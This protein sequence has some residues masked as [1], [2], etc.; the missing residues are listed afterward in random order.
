MLDEIRALSEVLDVNDLDLIA[1]HLALDVELLL[2]V[3]RLDLRFLDAGVLLGWREARHLEPGDRRLQV[4]LPLRERELEG[5][6]LPREREVLLLQ[7]AEVRTVHAEVLAGQPCDVGQGAAGNPQLV[8]VL[9]RLIASLLVADLG[10]NARNGL[11]D[12]LDLPDQVVERRESG[13]PE[14]LEDRGLVGV[15]DDLLALGVV[16]VEGVLVALR[17]LERGVESGLLCGA[18]CL[19]PRSPDPRPDRR[20][21]RREVAE[22]R[23]RR[24]LNPDLLLLLALERREER[25]ALAGLLRL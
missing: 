5:L 2:G 14:R 4:D 21:R 16:G 18:V 9:L 13:L 3:G 25:G 12:G 11:T 19:R 15:L 22:V 8:R 7:H 1:E 24:K 10:L 23:L 6:R 20:R 17:I